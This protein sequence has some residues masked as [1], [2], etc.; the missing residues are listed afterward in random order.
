MNNPF[1]SIII[2]TYNRKALIRATID[3]VLNQTYAD[4]E[5]IVVDDGSTDDTTNFLN[6]IY[7]D[8]IKVLSIENSER[9]RARNTGTGNAQG[10]YVYFLDSDDILYP[11][12]LKVAYA[13]IQEHNKPE[14]VFQEY[15]FLK[16]SG[17]TK[18]IYYNRTSPLNSLVSKGNFMSC[19]GVFLRKDIALTHPFEENR[20][21]AGSEDYALWLRLA[22]RFPLHINPIV[23]SALVQHDDRSV[24]NFAPDK[25]I[26]RKELML[27]TVLADEVVR[28][29]FAKLIPALKANTYS[30]VSLHLAMINSKQ[31]AFSYFLKSLKANPGSVFNKRTFAIIK[32]LIRQ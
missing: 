7:D 10:Q 25:L 4:Y 5:I 17:Q 13:F 2:P 14:W 1:F 9:G 28:I 12:H 27:K 11:N 20:Q 23:T 6:E 30:Y 18:P 22:A 26:A 15:E 16:E 8:S 31:N 29:R 24:F 3:S 32:H 19:H 21:M